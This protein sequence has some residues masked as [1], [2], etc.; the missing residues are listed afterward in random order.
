MAL[1]SI[2]YCRSNNRFIS[3][4]SLEKPNQRRSYVSYR[5]VVYCSRKLD[6]L[7][8]LAMAAPSTGTRLVA[9]I[10]AMESL[11]ICMYYCMSV[12]TCVKRYELDG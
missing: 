10:T 9:H 3:S 5:V 4:F 8:S 2:V 7:T 11:S 6:T 12:N 1:I